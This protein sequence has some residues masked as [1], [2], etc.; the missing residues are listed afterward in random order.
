MISRKTHP[1]G[2]T[3]QE[4]VQMLVVQ[5]PG[6]QNPTVEVHAMGILFD[7]QKQLAVSG[8]H[9]KIQKGVRVSGWH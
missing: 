9:C 7:P 8:Q 4:F 2:D 1:K 6:F 3:N 5:P